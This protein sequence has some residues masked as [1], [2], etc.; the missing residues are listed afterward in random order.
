MDAS[1][2]TIAPDAALPRWDL[3]PFF[4]G[5]DDRSFR[6]A[7]EGLVASITRLAARYDEHDVRGGDRRPATDDDRRV[8][9][10]LLDDTNAV[11]EQLRLVNAFLYALVTTDA[12][13]DGAAN[14]QAGLQQET[15]VLGA[16]T[17]RFEAWVARLA[18]GDGDGAGIDGEGDVGAEHGGG[19]TGDGRNRAPLGRSDDARVDETL[20][21]HAFV[22]RKAAAGAR[23]QMSEGE[24][25]LVAELR[26]SGSV[27]WARLHRDLTAR[28][29]A[30]VV[31]RDGSIVQL[32]MSVVRGRAHDADPA[33][34]K[35]AY[36]AEL[37][38]WKTVAVPLAAALNGA[39]GEL[40]VLNRRRGWADDLEPALFTNNIDR[41]TLD[42]MTAAVVD[43]LPD[44]RRYL[45]AKGRRLGHDDGLP[46]WDLF[47]PAATDA[48]AAAVS[49]DTAL[50]SVRDSF[51]TFSPN[52]A[53]LVD[54]AVDES[55]LDAEPRD[56]K[57][58]GAYC[59][60]VQ[61]DVSRVLLNFDGSL[62]SVATLAHELGHAYHNTN[63]GERSPL[64]RQ[65]PMALAETAS[66]FCETILVQASLVGADDTTRLAVLDTD[67]Q[68]ATQ[69]VVDIHSRFLFETELCRRRAAR[70]LSVDEL[71]ELMLETQEEAYGDG[72]DPGARHPH[73]W[74]V[75]GHYFTPFYNWPYTFGLLFGLGLHRRFLDD[76][77][78]FRR[79]YDT[80][81]SST[82][83]D[84]AATLAAGFG[85]DVRDEGFWASSLATIVERV[86]DYESLA[87]TVPGGRP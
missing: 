26:L 65:T 16:L 6:S 53:G 70:T 81:L 34:R 19:A 21:A 33:V 40:S 78:T 5:I 13:D 48:T 75:K 36:D 4:A 12:R 8:A 87:A 38:A 17:K 39:K 51:A 58:S 37:D 31:D 66:I 45:R 14:R 15:A 84:D 47:A 1:P 35:A 69:V 62:D 43:A 56:G 72:L 28:L 74:E 32:P 9:A 42:A 71:D 82:G 55:W 63:L 73:M 76:P 54:R 46:W 85:I 20:A 49:W 80:L 67:L 11:M 25:S 52:L 24:E 86:D 57:V 27:A 44:F 2:A 30:D 3:S 60:P 7:H 64:Q 50:R 41:A 83:L 10:Q 61:R 79:H 23:H 29:T 77:D 18:D 22:L 68:G 59:L